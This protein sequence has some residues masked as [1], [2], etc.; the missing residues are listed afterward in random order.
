MKR[1]LI[2]A[3]AALPLT[4][5]TQDQVLIASAVANGGCLLANTV[6]GAG[7]TATEINLPANAD[8]ATS[9]TL[10]RWKAGQAVSTAACAQ[11]A[12]ALQA[13]GQQVVALQVSK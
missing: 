5:C 2:A 6:T 9:K 11:I 13:V 8:P 10:A 4:G 7:I 3:A 1:I 12:A